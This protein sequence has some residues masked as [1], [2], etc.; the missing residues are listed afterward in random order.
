MPRRSAPSD[1]P[2]TGRRRGQLI[3]PPYTPTEWRLLTRL[4][5]Q[6]LVAAVRIR[7]TEAPG[8]SDRAV[9]DG[10][11]GLEGFAA[12]RAFDSDLVRAV[13]RAIYAEADEDFAVLE[14]L[15]DRGAMRAEL[16]AACHA[17]VGLLAERTDLADS[18]AYR[19]WVQSIAARVCHAAGAAPPG[20][21][22]KIGVQQQRFLDE[23]G[24]VLGLA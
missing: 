21:D 3:P 16:F 23:L 2:V 10:L 24:V 11:A 15:A 13:V 8:T 4:P 5:G 7:S 14:S 12:G 6:V 9:A 19:Q 1:P 18:A 22:A 20:F 17:A